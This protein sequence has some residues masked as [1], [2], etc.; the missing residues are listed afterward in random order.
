MRRDVTRLGK[1]VSMAILLL[2]ATPALPDMYTATTAYQKGDF[3]TA[4][5][6]FKELAELGNPDAQLNLAVMYGK[7][8]GVASNNVLAHAWASIAVQ[9]GEERA[10]TLAATLEPELTPNSL[11]FSKDMQAEY[12][13]SALNARL[14]PRMRKGE[15]Y[16]DRDPVKLSKAFTPSYPIDAQRKGVQG[17]AYVEFIVAPD[18]HPRSPRILYVVPSNY[19]E[20]AIR[21]SIFRTLYLPARINGKPVAASTGIYFNFKIASVSL[22][23]YGNLEKQVEDTKTRAEAGDPSAQM[24][25]GMMVAGLP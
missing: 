23:D 8:Q 12:S 13:Q 11:R 1:S 4:F 9:N 10:A 24:L 3:T 25:Y 18:G 6:Q 19:F 17:E 14:L 16:E 7:G 21:E 5:Q 20:D 2:I 22:R 15:E